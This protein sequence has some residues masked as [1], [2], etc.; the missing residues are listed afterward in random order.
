MPSNRASS[1]RSRI[2]NADRKIV[3]A[4]RR[5]YRL[6]GKRTAAPLQREWSKPVIRPAR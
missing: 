2:A 4:L 6:D 5:S 3:D 1:I